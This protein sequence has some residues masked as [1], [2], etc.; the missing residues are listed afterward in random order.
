MDKT[1]YLDLDEYDLLG[2]EGDKL[3]DKVVSSIVEGISEEDEFP[4]VP[5]I[6]VNDL[7]YCL[8]NKT[9]SMPNGKLSILVDGGHHRAYGHYISNKPLK[10]Y[11]SDT[12]EK[13]DL[14]KMTSISTWRPQEDHGEYEER[15]EM[16]QDYR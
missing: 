8:C 9:R 11:M 1:F 5:V 12:K 4:A 14:G 6:K 16:F 13:P 2:W 10:C 3:S 15:I 7:T